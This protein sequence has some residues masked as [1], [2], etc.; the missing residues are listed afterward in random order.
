MA[1]E[2]FAALQEAG[3]VVIEGKE[4]VVR[5][6]TPYYRDRPDGVTEDNLLAL[7]RYEPP[8]QTATPDAPPRRAA[9]GKART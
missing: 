6:G 9:V 5:E 4:I 7:P 8:F 1:P 3:A 2:E